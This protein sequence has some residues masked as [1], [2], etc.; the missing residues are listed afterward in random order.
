MSSSISGSLP[1]PSSSS[2]VVE[3]LAMRRGGTTTAR[4]FEKEL[5]KSI[6][7]V[8]RLLLTRRSGALD[9]HGDVC[10]GQSETGEGD[11]KGHS[12]P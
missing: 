7:G 6:I 2:G 8:E 1:D 3:R 10:S 11:A 12:L 9:A 5:E 4:K